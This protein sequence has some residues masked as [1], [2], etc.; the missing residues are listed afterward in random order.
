[1]L[2][3]KSDV[4]QRRP[5]RREQLLVALLADEL[6]VLLERRNRENP[7]AHFLVAHL[8]AEALGLGERRALVDHL[9]QNLLLDAEL[10]EQCSLMLPPY[11]ERYACSCAW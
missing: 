2:S 1:M 6:A 4:R 8:D 7:L 3:S 10:L 9:L 5:L 11:A